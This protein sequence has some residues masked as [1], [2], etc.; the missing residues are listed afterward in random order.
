M[1]SLGASVVFVRREISRRLL[2]GMLGFAAGIMLAASYGSLLSPSIE[3]STEL[4]HLAWGPAA[5]GFTLGGSMVRAADKA[6]PHLHLF[7]GTRGSG[8]DVRTNH[9]ARRSGGIAQRR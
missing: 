4:G 6:L 1:T 2:D 5:I 7:V 3:L 8:G 9:V